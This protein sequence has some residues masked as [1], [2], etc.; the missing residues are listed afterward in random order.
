MNNY[1]VFGNSPQQ[2][3]LRQYNRSR[4]NSPPKNRQQQQQH[5]IKSPEDVI[6]SSN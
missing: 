3:Y 1:N 4:S 6:Y 2:I 5:Y